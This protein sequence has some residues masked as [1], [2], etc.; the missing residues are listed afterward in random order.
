MNR[1]INL[2]AL[3]SSNTNKV[4]VDL[5]KPLMLIGYQNVL[6]KVDGSVK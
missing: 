3:F 6:V 2:V 1:P 5:D 4:L